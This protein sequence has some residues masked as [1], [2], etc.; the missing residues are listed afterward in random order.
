MTDLS[1]GNDWIK[2]YDQFHVA[3]A[4]PGKPGKFYPLQGIVIPTPVDQ[5]T[6]AVA[7]STTNAKPSWQ[8]GGRVFSIISVIGSDIGNARTQKYHAVYLDQPTIIQMTRYAIRYQIGIG[9][10]SW[11][12]S[13]Y[14][15]AWAFVGVE[16]TDTLEQ[17][18]DNIQIQL[19]RIEEQLNTTTGQ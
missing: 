4:V 13:A 9:I 14:I 19:N 11:F 8:F 12:E 17:K 7:I 5:K 18:V 3:Q 6:I 15:Q 10:P 16:P 2:I 1:N